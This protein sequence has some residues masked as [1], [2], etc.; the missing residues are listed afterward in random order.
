MQR[1]R[2]SEEPCV[3]VPSHRPTV[4]QWTVIPTTMRWIHSNHLITVKDSVLD[5]LNDCSPADR[6]LSRPI[7]IDT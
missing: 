5:V 3:D 2:H 6:R 7:N 4:I 1:F